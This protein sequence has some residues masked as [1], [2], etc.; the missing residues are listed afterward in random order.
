MSFFQSVFALCPHISPSL[1]VCMKLLAPLL[2]SPLLYSLPHDIPPHFLDG[3]PVLLSLC[4]F[5]APD[6]RLLRCASPT[7]LLLPKLWVFF[8]GLISLSLNHQSEG[9]MKTR[10]GVRHARQE[11][12]ASCVNKPSWFLVTQRDLETETRKKS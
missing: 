3:L 1:S 11:R 5:L 4:H 9:W 2:S 12:R 8:S 10:V 7:P 6:H